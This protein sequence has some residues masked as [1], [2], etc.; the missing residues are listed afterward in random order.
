MAGSVLCDQIAGI[1]FLGILLFIQVGP[2]YY[3][4]TR[5]EED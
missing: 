3:L 4:I 5:E 2:F 1:L